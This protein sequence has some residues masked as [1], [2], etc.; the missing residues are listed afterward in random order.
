MKKHL[1]LLLS[2][3]VLLVS[4]YAQT[5]PLQYQINQSATTICPSAPVT[6]SVAT[7]ANL[8][9]TPISG[10]STNAASSGGTITNDGGATITA[11][12]V[13]W[14]T[15]PNPTTA[16]PTKTSNGTGTGVFTSNMT[17]LLSNTIYYVRAYAT[18]SN[19][20][21]YGNELIFNGSTATCGATNVHNPTKTYGSMTDQNGNVYKTIVIG[22]Q[23]WMAENLKAS[24]YRDGTTSIPTINDAVQWTGLTTGASCWYANNSASYDC[25]YGKLYNWYAVADPRNLCP[26]GWHV[27]SDAEWT[28][29]TNFL[30][31]EALAGGKMKSTG[32]QYWLS[33]NTNATNESGF[34][35]LPGGFRSYYFGTFS[36]VG[37]SGF[38]WSSSVSAA[39]NAWYRALNHTNSNAYR[40]NYDKQGGLSVRCLRD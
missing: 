17:G 1:L 40:N 39:V 22:T 28:T 32:T 30:G 8:T 31:G 14:N 11:R 27:P 24:T 26:T 23:T 19:G 34:S 9:T 29:L 12:G 18:N 13:A 20:T 35:G 38:W 21:Y 16:L 25:P 3:F 7:L 33:P 4:V 5:T 6:I 15:L 10:I 2:F 37:T 36:D